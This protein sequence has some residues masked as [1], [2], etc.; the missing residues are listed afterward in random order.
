[1]NTL[2]KYFMY[3]N[4]LIILSSPAYSKDQ[5]SPIEHAIAAT[6]SISVYDENDNHISSGSGFVMPDGRIATNY[7]VI[8]GGDRVEITSAS[9]KLLLVTDYMEAFSKRYDLAILPKVN[10][11]PA[12]LSL[13]QSKL[14]VGSH[15]YVVGAPL[16]LQN[17]VSD[18]IVSAYRTEDGVSYIQITA[19]I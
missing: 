19:P 5:G 8:D 4:T 9:G 7:H 1:M 17:S 13:A 18:G 10:L 14:G 16:G 3:V 6:V 2:I 12:R 11:S 15:I